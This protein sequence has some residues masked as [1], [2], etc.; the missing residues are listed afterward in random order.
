MSFPDVILHWPE[1]FIRL[2]VA[3]G[4]SR[5]DQRARRQFV[6]INSKKSER[7]SKKRTITPRSLADKFR[8]L[9]T[10]RKQVHE[11][12]TVKGLEQQRST[13]DR[14]NQPE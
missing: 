5:E 13:N 6:M 11:L 12:E 4:D 2:S 1:T 10:L 3:I 7:G 14:R 8:E 9:Q